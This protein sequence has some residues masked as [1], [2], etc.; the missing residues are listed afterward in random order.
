MDGKSWL[1]SAN[2]EDKALDNTR[3]SSRQKDVS[4]VEESGSATLNGLKIIRSIF[5]D[6]NLTNTPRGQGKKP[7]QSLSQLA[8]SSCI[9]AS[10]L[11]VV[12]K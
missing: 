6:A 12:F 3:A 10:L 2:M 5:S 4:T 8:C 1:H 9:R 11:F 7:E